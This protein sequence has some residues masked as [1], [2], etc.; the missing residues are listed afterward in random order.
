MIAV[1]PEKYA[2]YSLKKAIWINDCDFFEQVFVKKFGCTGVRFVYGN[3]NKKESCSVG[4][5]FLP[6]KVVFHEKWDSIKE[7]LLNIERSFQDQL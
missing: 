7:E 6:K 2:T 1:C 3:P 5:L 4:V